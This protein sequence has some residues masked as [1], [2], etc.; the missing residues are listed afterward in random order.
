[1]TIQLGDRV[2]FTS[3]EHKANFFTQLREAA[4]GEELWENVARLQASRWKEKY[5]ALIE[6]TID[7]RMRQVSLHAKMLA[8]RRG[9]TLE[10]LEDYNRLNQRFGYIGNQQRDYGPVMGD[11][12]VDKPMSNLVAGVDQL[13]Y[14]ADFVAPLLPV[15]ERS[16]EIFRYRPEDTHTIDLDIERAPGAPAVELG[17]GMD[18]RVGFGIRN[19]SAQ[20]PIPREWVQQATP[21][22]DVVEKTVE[23]LRTIVMLK[24]EIRVQALL[25][26][27]TNFAAANRFTTTTKWDA[28]ATNNEHLTDL[29]AARDAVLDSI[30]R[31]PNWIILTRG[32]ARAL[33]DKDHF[34]NKTIH[35]VTSMPAALLSLIGQYVEVENVAIGQARYNTASPGAAAPSFAD[36]WSDDVVLLRV[37]AASRL[38]GGFAISPTTDAGTIETF[39]AADRTRKSTMAAMNQ[40]GTEL[41]VRDTAGAHIA[42]VLTG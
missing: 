7:A 37:E 23:T 19:Y 18:T 28:D 20:T 24:R 40:E 22:L 21:P 15:D 2:S 12:H 30:G 39:E 8:D 5:A 10:D 25:Q 3:E 11:I 27:N 4:R 17:W 29:R 13:P 32:A 26:T 34:T 1:M 38:F 14:I 6:S 35:T 9:V 33:I 36:V 41:V 42:D 16:G 31:P